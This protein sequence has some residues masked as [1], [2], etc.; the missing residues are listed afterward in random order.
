MTLS[1]GELTRPIHKFMS[2]F[3]LL[4]S[5]RASLAE[6]CE[7]WP[8]WADVESQLDFGLQFISVARRARGRKTPINIHKAPESQFRFR[9]D[10]MEIHCR[11]RCIN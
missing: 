9:E 11:S 7:R 2:K 10:L 4:G 8:F 6:T 1:C 5:L 3:S